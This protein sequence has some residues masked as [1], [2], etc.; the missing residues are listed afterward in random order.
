MKRKDD[1]ASVAMSREFAKA[2]CH[3]AD[4]VEK[5]AHSS[6]ETEH[7]GEV[8]GKDCSTYGPKHREYTGELCHKSR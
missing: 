3:R 2:F 4:A 1:S 6:G 7:K 5:L 8:K